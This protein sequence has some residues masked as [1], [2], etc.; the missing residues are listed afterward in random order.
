MAGYND[1]SGKTFN[2]WTVIKRVKLNNRQVYYLCKCICGIKREINHG[3]LTR[4]T[5]KSCGCTRGENFDKHIGEKYGMLTIIEIKNVNN[6]Q[7][8]CE[9]ECECGNKKDIRLYAVKNGKATS[10]GCRNPNFRGVGGLGLRWWNNHVIRPSKRMD[11]KV[12][13]NI[14]YAWDL[15]LKQ[16]RKCALTG[17]S[18]RFPKNR[19]DKEA[20]A[21][22]DR[23]DN[24]KGY[25]KGNVQW[26]TK[27][28]NMFKNKYND[29][30]F[31]DLCTQVVET[32]THNK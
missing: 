16:N 3:S 17:R 15:F 30:E 31:I 27:Q 5:S 25:V 6:G 7:R 26:V 22:F 28:I 4:G 1:L 20:N 9:C 13:I 21:S 8:M 2:N 18:I 11:R 29:D 23:K 10:C 19:N 32:F 14:Q 12:D 24:S